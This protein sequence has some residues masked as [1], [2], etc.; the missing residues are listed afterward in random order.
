[1]LVCDRCKNPVTSEDDNVV[2]FTDRQD[3]VMF[4]G[5]LCAACS[6]A[7]DDVW[8]ACLRNEVPIVREKAMPPRRRWFDSLAVGMLAWYGWHAASRLPEAIHF[9]ANLFK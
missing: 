6:K 8:M 5:H 9:F 2:R 1:M 7:C 3:A 4:D